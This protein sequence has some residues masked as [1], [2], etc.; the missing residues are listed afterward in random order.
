VSDRRLRIWIDLAKTPHRLFLA[1]GICE[2]ERRPRRA[3][4]AIDPLVRSQIVPGICA[5]AA[6][7]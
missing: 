5:T 7:S 1:P 2:L 4:L 3:L 6:R